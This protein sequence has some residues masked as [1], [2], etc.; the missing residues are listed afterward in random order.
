MLIFLDLTVAFDAVDHSAFSSRQE[1]VFSLPRKP[2]HCYHSH[3][4]PCSQRVSVHAVLCLL[5]DIQK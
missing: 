1:D 5:S 3:L 2:L 4:E